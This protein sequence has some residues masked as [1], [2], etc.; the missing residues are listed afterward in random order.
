MSRWRPQHY[1]RKALDHGFDPTLVD[2]AVRTGAL[3]IACHADRPPVFSLRHLAHMANVRYYWLRTIVS[4]QFDPYRLIRIHKR[5]TSPSNRYR[6]IC[7][8]DPPLL[9]V[10]RWI[11]QNILRTAAPHRASSAFAPGDDIVSAA[12]V[13]TN[14]RWLIKLD[15]KNV[16]E[17]ISEISVYRVF[18]S[19]GYQPL[20]AFE[21]ARLCTRVRTRPG[22]YRNPRWRSRS[23]RYR[24]SSYHSGK[25]G[26]VPQGAPTSPML[27][28]LTMSDLDE[29]VDAIATARGLRYSRYAD[30]GVPRRHARRL[31]NDQLLSSYAA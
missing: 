19:L 20:I 11:A 2:N 1:R 21:L 4:R 17:S 22:I 18:L 5:V 12:H 14:A 28:N 13:H 7:I 26:Y 30:D 3:T 6:I 24:I 9:C 25:L 16:F 29:A 8:P 23:L 15:V 10:Q 27:S 31:N